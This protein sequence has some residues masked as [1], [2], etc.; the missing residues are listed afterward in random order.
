MGILDS[1]FGK[2]K[3]SV[4]PKQQGN[5]RTQEEVTSIPT[6]MYNEP[7]AMQPYV[8][9]KKPVLIIGGKYN[10]KQVI[11]TSDP[12]QKR[13]STKSGK[14]WP[15]VT[16]EMVTSGESEPVRTLAVPKAKERKAEEKEEQFYTITPDGD[17]VPIEKQCKSDRKN[18]QEED[19]D[20]SDAF[21]ASEISNRLC[22]F[23]EPNVKHPN[24][25]E[26]Y[27]AFCSS[28]P[29][30]NFYMDDEPRLIDAASRFEQ[31]TIR[32]ARV[33]VAAQEAEKKGN[34]TNAALCYQTLV[35]QSYWEP[36]P[37]DRL[38]QLYQKSGQTDHYRELRTHAIR[39]F[40]ERRKRME[41]QLIELAEQQDD[42]SLAEEAIKEK[43]KVSYYRGLF[44]VYDPFPLLE[45]WQADELA[46]P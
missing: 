13:F 4:P 40:N 35:S 45:K 33:I 20:I 9:K 15:G 2:K 26:Q 25:G 5:Q 14:S 39:F 21:S 19:T 37:Y 6:L 32:P 24:Y 8:D 27:D 16:I 31:L 18:E 3:T 44:V 11:L 17:L 23:L 38:M 46:N 1:I 7:S 42:R 43:R 30:F 28:F 36:E 10:Q 34:Y 41:Q 22:Y 29:A 12:R